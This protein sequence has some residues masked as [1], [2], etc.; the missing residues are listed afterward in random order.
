MTDT[1]E[2]HHRRSIRLKGYDYSQAGAYFVT[3]CTDDRQNIFGEIING[4]MHLNHIG[5]IIKTE[6]DKTPKIRSNV[7]L[8]ESVI[9]PNHV[10]GIILILDDGRGVSP[11]APTTFRSPSKNLG[12][13][14]RGFKS[15]TTKQINEARKSFSTSVWQRNYYEHIIRNE[16][17]LNRI[18][19]YSVYNP[20]RWQF[21]RENLEGKPD[22]QE[23]DF[24][25][26]FE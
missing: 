21:D 17:E 9:M 5:Q 23:I 18:R 22:Q 8:D 26:N 3:I 7:D 11:Y 16:H 19:E 10:H 1:S 4:K 24:W 13:I 12:A 14:V 20:L 25:K 2:K 6:W 15:T